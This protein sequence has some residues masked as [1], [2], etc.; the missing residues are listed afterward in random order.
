[1]YSDSFPKGHHLIMVE[2]GRRLIRYNIDPDYVALTAAAEIVRDR[3]ADAIYQA[4]SL[5]P[6]CK[7]L[8]KEQLAAWQQFIDVMGEEGRVVD[9]A[10]ANDV[11][12]EVIAVLK[13]KVDKLL[14]TPSV[15]RAYER[16]KF[17]AELTKEHDH[18]V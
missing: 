7:D 11:T 8:T 17:V 1:M 6:R 12:S 14:N 9:S 13:A 16:F 3:V 5:R 18:G 15:R 4:S 10:S 2:P